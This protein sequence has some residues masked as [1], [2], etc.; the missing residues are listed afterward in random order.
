M[1]RALKLRRPTLTVSPRS[2]PPAG[3]GALKPPDS[4]RFMAEYCGN[5]RRSSTILTRISI[6]CRNLILTEAVE[7]SALLESVE[8]LHPRQVLAVPES[9]QNPCNSQIP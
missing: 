5:P 1:I 6:N 2:I 3:L 9:E 7:E 4:V 8:W